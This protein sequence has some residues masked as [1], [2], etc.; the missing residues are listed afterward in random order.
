MSA[1]PLA[2]APRER[3][4]A[5]PRLEGTPSAKPEGTP[6]PKEEE[7]RMPLAIPWVVVT[8]SSRGTHEYAIGHAL[9][10]HLARGWAAPSPAHQRGCRRVRH[11]DARRIGA[12]GFAD[13]GGIR[14][15]RDV[16]AGA[17][18]GRADAAVARPLHVPGA[19]QD[20]RGPPH[21]CER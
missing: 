9:D 7:S 5:A 19:V 12:R 10:P 1:R 13:A 20:T 8:P 14:R 17:I 6:S 3:R 2:P 15:I 11:R 18:E 4:A 16:D 21:Q